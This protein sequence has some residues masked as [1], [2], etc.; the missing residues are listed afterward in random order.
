MGGII[1][2]ACIVLSMVMWGDLGNAY[3]WIMILSLVGYGAIGLLDDYLKVIRKNPKGLR[4]WYKFGAQIGI[5]LVIGLVLYS[6]PDDPYRS[7]L[8]VPF[9]KKWFFD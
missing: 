7:E 9:F 2:I 8:I 6:N 5:A 1:V 3:I 4:A